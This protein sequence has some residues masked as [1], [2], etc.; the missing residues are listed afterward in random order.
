MEVL[1]VGAVSVDDAIELLLDPLGLKDLAGHGAI[2][3]AVVDAM[4]TPGFYGRLIADASSIDATTRGHVVFAVFHGD[5]SGITYR[6]TICAHPCLARYQVRGFSIS[7]DQDV[8]VVAKPDLRRIQPEIDPRLAEALGYP[9]RSEVD[10]PTLPR[11]GHACRCLMERYSIP[12]AALPCLLFVEAGDPTKNIII[13]LSPQNPLPSL[14]NALRSIAHEFADLC[15]LLEG[16]RG[17]RRGSASSCACR[18]RGARS[19]CK[20]REV[21]R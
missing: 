20:D 19:A 21:Q 14:N 12:E 17:D 2:C 9:P 11:I 16:A 3:F 1:T 4:T 15:S 18:Y 5:R 13:R 10:R 7:A 8:Y 6:A